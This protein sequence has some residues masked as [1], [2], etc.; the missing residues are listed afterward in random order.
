MGI[1]NHQA[2]PDFA[3]GEHDGE[4]RQQNAQAHSQRCDSLPMLTFDGILP[5]GQVVTVLLQEYPFFTQGNQDVGGLLEQP[6]Q[7]VEL[8]A[9]ILQRRAL[10]TIG[11]GRQCVAARG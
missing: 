1:P 8:I 2:S 7:G 10:C 11:L 5:A 6:C 9:D 3:T 4:Q